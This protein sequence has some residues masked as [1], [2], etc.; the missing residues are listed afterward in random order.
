LY[1]ASVLTRFGSRYD[2]K[3]IV[4]RAQNKRQPH[5]APQSREKKG[6]G[7]KQTHKVG[8][9]ADMTRSHCTRPGAAATRP[10]RGKRSNVMQHCSARCGK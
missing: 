6:D 4:L 5:R 2:A 8:R 7:H 10:C 9:R 1:A 3:N